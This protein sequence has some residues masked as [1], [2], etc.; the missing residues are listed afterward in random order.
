MTTSTVLA[1]VIGIAC[2]VVGLSV[3]NR[4]HFS[5]VIQELLNNRS[6]LW[7]TGF[8]TVVFGAAIISLYS[9]WSTNWRVVI[10]IVGW[11][12]LLKGA[13]IMFFPHKI[14]SL[15]SRINTGAYTA[16]AGVVAIV[17][18]IFLLYASLVA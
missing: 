5:V 13:A 10:T 14:A 15:Y 12:S 8:V 16:I 9:V 17:L 4:K 11:L 3:L 2:I 7:L 1:R 18:G 6:T